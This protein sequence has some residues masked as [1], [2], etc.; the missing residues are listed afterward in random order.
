MDTAEKVKVFSSFDELTHEIIRDM[1]THDMLAQRYAVRFIMLNNFNEF[2]KLAKFMADKGVDALDLENLISEGEDDE[3]ITKDTLKDAIKSCKQSTFVT[4]FSEL[5]RFFN[6]D[7]FRGFFNEIM[8]LEDIHNPNKRIYV[9]L[10]GLQNRFTDFLNHFARIKESAPIWRY[11]A[12]S[13]SVEVF[14]A[15]YK[16]FTLPNGAVQCQLDSLREWLKFWKVQAPQERIVCTSMPIAAKYKYSRPDNIFNFTRIEN[17]YT[18]MTC[19]LDLNFPFAYDKEEKSFW[20]EMLNH[21]D[22]STL[23]SFSFQSFVPTYFNR[24]KFDAG[25]IIMEWSDSNNKAFDRWLLSKYILHTGFGEEYPYIKICV[26]AVVDLN[27]ESEL[28]KMIATRVVYDLP[29][30]MRE[31]Y[32][33]E[34]RKVI[35]HN[36]LIFEKFLA[37]SEQDWLFER[38]KETF[39]ETGDLHQA[40]DICTGIF[41]F[42]KKLLMGWYVYHPEN[43]RLKNAIDDFYPDFAA[44]LETNKPSQFDASTQWAIDYIKNYKQAKLEDKYLDSIAGVIKEKNGSSASF[45]QWY[46][47]FSSSHDLLAEISSNPATRPDK[48]YWID[49][50]GVEFL[51]YIMHVI[52]EENSNLKVVRSQ[53]ARSELPSSTHHNRFEGCNVK[54]FA[55]LDELGHDSHGYKQFDTLRQEL[56][57]LRDIIQ[58]IIATCKKEKCTVAIVSDHGLSCLSRKAPSKKY[59]GKFEHEG[60]Y[61]KT[62]ADAN[63]DSDYLVH[64]NVDESQYYKVALTHSSLSKIPT[65]QVHGGCTPEEVLVPFVLL[66]NKK[67]SSNI[68]TY[69]IVMADEDIMLS[70]PIV[71]LSVIPEPAGVML[72]C[73]GT[74]YQMSRIGTHWT[75]ELK[76]ITE[77]SH[78]IDI[79]P[80]GAAGVEMKIRVVGVGG[81]MNIDDMFDL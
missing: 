18:F 2:K 48:I 58:E 81:N 44:Y 63:S 64:H 22:K 20:E 1:E 11:D 66:S 23:A 80:E 69:Q 59:D 43:R 15:K 73:N 76:D 8:L 68:V 79:K 21:I 47:E 29:G 53:I 12:E 62:T 67:G 30:N 36:H 51:S 19:F 74:N 6:D 72:T 14:F 78:L 34:R 55:E 42:E 10:I 7:D 52:E 33:E 65:H 38:V 57:V 75:A 60:R 46:Y 50:L 16:D 4:P 25:D 70:N 41:D 56:K 37:R 77:G 31:Q 3:W 54:K 13:Q 9:P 24:V 28:I 40:V 39:Q 61:I 17:A 35:A 5:V 45:Y 27:D 49:G 71:K 26:E 32:A